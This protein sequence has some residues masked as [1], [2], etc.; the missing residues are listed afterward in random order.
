MLTLEQVIDK[1]RLENEEL[2]EEIEEGRLGHE[3]RIE[4]N[5]RGKIS[6]KKFVLWLG[7]AKNYLLSMQ[8][9]GKYFNEVSLIEAFGVNF[10]TKLIRGDKSIGFIFGK[11]EEI[12][13]S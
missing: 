13:K 1:T 10:K 4:L 6:A 11:L 7:S 2:V 12:V 3:L 9:I 5:E 8:E